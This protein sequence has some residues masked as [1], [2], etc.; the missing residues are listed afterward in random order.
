MRMHHRLIALFSMLLCLIVLN[1][2]TRATA[3]TPLTR[4]YYA[5]EP[6]KAGDLVMANDSA[7]ISRVGMPGSNT[8]SRYGKNVARIMDVQALNATVRARLLS[9]HRRRLSHRGRHN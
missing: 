6:I 8:E 4:T 2:T 5:A 3:Q 7:M 1:G 9:D